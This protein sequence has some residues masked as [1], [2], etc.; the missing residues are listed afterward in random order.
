MKLSI[1][2]RAEIIF[3]LTTKFPIEILGWL[4]SHHSQNFSRFLQ[5]QNQSEV[6][7]RRKYGALTYVE[8]RYHLW[9]MY[10]YDK[11]NNF[12]IH[13]LDLHSI[14]IFVYIQIGIE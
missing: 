2:A 1:C 12:K 11:L 5:I 10:K 4:P 14:E 6:K 7:F 13:C 3:G 8:E 9:S